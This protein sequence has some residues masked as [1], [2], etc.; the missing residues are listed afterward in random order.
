VAAEAT[1][2]TGRQARASLARL[3]ASGVIGGT[4]AAQAPQALR[5]ALLRFLARFYA[6]GWGLT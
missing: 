3:S 2:H 4:P 5:R 1:Y 6:W